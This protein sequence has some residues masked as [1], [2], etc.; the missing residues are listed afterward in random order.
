MLCDTADRA[1]HGSPSGEEWR[2][3]PASTTEGFR[4]V[5]GA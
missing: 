5:I 3:A 1:R 2:T 4:Q